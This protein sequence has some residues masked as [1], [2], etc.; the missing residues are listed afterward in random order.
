MTKQYDEVVVI[1]G[2]IAGLAAALALSPLAARVTVLE[3]SSFEQFHDVESGAA[4]QLSDNGLKALKF[5]SPELLQKVLLHSVQVQKSYII[6][7]SGSE[8]YD[9]I[10]PIPP[11]GTRTMMI[12]WGILRNLLFEAIPKDVVRIEFNTVVKDFTAGIL[13]TAK[14][15][16]DERYHISDRTLLVAADGS[17]SAFRHTPIRYSPRLNIKAAIQF[18]DFPSIFE[19]YSTYSYLGNPDVA[20]FL[21]PAGPQHYYWAISLATDQPETAN[22]S[23]DQVIS[24]LT[25]PETKVWRDLLQATPPHKVF[26]QPSVQ[27]D[28]PEEMARGNVVLVGD[29]AHCMSG[30]YGQSACLALEDAVTLATEPLQNYTLHR[31]QRC[32]DLQAASQHRATQAVNDK[33]DAPSAINDW[34][35]KW[36]VPA[37]SQPEKSSSSFVVVG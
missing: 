11:Q 12:R 8:L 20:C 10:A 18:S 32:L 25:S 22:P 17:Q 37:A 6:M 2:S 21:G 23:V 5:L 34:I 15:D 13:T 33:S 27:A 24:R 35:F 36:D 16:C 14:P 19:R 30:S 4:L 28:I 3:A 1:G 9:T 29:A 7:P 26:R 31:R